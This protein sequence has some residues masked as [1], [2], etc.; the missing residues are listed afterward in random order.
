[1]TVRH[2]ATAYLRERAL[3]RNSFSRAQPYSVHAKCYDRLN[4]NTDF[5][6]LSRFNGESRESRNFIAIQVEILQP[7]ACKF[8]IVFL[9]YFRICSQCIT[10]LLKYS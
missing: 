7:H 5:R 8:P 4:F 6:S 1:M 10:V 9:S 3:H 2:G